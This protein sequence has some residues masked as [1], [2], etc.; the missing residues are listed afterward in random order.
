M[1][2]YKIFFF[3]LYIMILAALVSF[4]EPAGLPEDVVAKTNQFR[5]ANGLGALQTNNYLNELAQ[6]HSEA[7][8]K[9]RTSFGHDGFKRRNDLATAKLKTISSFA[10]N[11]AFGA[12]TATQVVNNWK[13]SAGHRKNMLGKSYKYIGVGVAKSKNGQLFYTQLFGG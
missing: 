2:T 4:S 10:E 11:V 7:M 8:A 13:N 6:K 1:K 9:G 5:K 12:T 3:P